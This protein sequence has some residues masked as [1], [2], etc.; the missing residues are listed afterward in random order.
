M[1][2]LK[3]EFKK[4]G[5]FYY[6]VDRT[7]RVALYRLTIKDKT[8]E[9]TVG[10]EVCKIYTKPSRVIKGNIL[11]ASEVIPSNNQFAWYDDSRAFFPSELEE[12]K[13]Y[14][15]SYGKLLQERGEKNVRIVLP[16]KAINYD[17]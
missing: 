16:Y 11:E 14:L 8:G 17:L 4:N 5:L 9:E 7:N 10:Y 15:K 3:E 6:L 2:Q 13:E 1:K 12:A